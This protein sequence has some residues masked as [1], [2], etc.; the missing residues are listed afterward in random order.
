M[1]NGTKFCPHCGNQLSADA[2]FC[3]RCGFAMANVSDSVSQPQPEPAPTPVEPVQTTPQRTTDPTAN[4]FTWFVS[5]LKHPAEPIVG[6]NRLFGPGLLLIELLLTIIMIDVVDKASRTVEARY[7]SSSAYV[8]SEIGHNSLRT[9]IGLGII[10]LLFILITLGLS[11]GIRRLNDQR[12]ELDFWEFTNQFAGISSFALIISLVTFLAT[13]MI[14][15]DSDY[16]ADYW[17]PVLLIP[18]ALMFNLSYVYST[19][20]ETEKPRWEKLYVI[21]VSEVL[22]IVICVGIIYFLVK[23]HAMPVL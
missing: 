1:E 14:K 15:I 12:A 19:I 17:V 2:K 3:P 10:I 5:S 21:L 13:F 7:D 23:Q 9:A 6:A 16:S 8:F 18:L 11:Y 22:L 4:P 20:R